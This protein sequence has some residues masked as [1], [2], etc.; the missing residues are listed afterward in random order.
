MKNFEVH[1][2]D[3]STNKAIKKLDGGN[4][5]RAEKIER[6]VNINLDHERFYT[7]VVQPLPG[8]ADQ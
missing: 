7:T 3:R 2:I 6:G 1:I 5:R 8:G 4:E